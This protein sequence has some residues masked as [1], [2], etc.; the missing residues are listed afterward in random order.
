MNRYYIRYVIFCFSLL[1]ILNT[2]ARADALDS[3][4]ITQVQEAQKDELKGATYNNSQNRN[5]RKTKKAGAFEDEERLS[6][7]EKAELAV[8]GLAESVAA[9]H[10]TARSITHGT[11]GLAQA[12]PAHK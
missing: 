6:E 5:H 7:Q 8:T 1:F 2:A 10:Q 12:P 9:S 3:A 4:M 11:N